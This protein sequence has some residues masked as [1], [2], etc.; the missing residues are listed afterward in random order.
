[1]T[2]PTVA[3]FAG[4]G[5]RHP[6]NT[7]AGGPY[8][9]PVAVSAFYL[10]FFRLSHDDRMPHRLRGLLRILLDGFIAYGVAYFVIPEPEL[11]EPAPGHPERLC[12]DTPLTGTERAL[13]RQLADEEGLDLLRWRSRG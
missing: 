12:P 3:H 7:R 11:V 13:A 5:A 4:A 8:V 9:M 1:M 2:V 10:G 6:G